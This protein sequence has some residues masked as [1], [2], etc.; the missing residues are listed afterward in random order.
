MTLHRNQ[1]V[2]LKY[3]LALDAMLAVLGRRYG[4]ILDWSES[5]TPSSYLCVVMLTSCWLLIII[6]KIVIICQ[7]L[8]HH[9]Q[10]RAPLTD[11]DLRS[12]LWCRC[13][14]EMGFYRVIFLGGIFLASLT[15][16]V[17][18]LLLVLKDI[19]Y[20]PTF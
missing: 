17:W 10:H 11:Y 1:E 18:V 5:I 15:L 7:N 3:A 12:S 4:S 16:R 2:S 6:T 14:S 8:H 9:H 19:P 20:R 13:R